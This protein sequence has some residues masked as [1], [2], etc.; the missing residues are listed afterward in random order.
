LSIYDH[1][2][3]W[4]SITSVVD[5]GT[6]EPDEGWSVTSDSGFDYSRP[7]VIRCPSHLHSFSSDRNRFKRL[8]AQV[9]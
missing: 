6:G 7:V 2:V 1:S 9:E 3:N 5:S 8:S 4:G